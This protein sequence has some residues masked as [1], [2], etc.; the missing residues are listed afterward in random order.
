MITNI[1]K[2]F[3]RLKGHDEAYL[4]TLVKVYPIINGFSRVVVGPLMDY[5]SFKILYATVNI[6]V[7]ILSS[8]IYYISENATLYFIYNVISAICLGTNFA[9]FPTFISKKFGL[10]YDFR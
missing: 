8:S 4:S 7:I 1:N 6:F 3:G 2:N 5:V 9:I 10:K